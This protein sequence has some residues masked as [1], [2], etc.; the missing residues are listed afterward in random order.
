[1]SELQM[2]RGHSAGALHG[3]NRRTHP[4]W[5]LESTFLGMELYALLHT[6]VVYGMGESTLRVL[7]A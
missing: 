7:R 5:C 3:I 1:M 6:L 4:T 2:M